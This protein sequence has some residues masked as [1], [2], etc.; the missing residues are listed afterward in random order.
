MSPKRTSVQGAGSCASHL[1]HAPPWKEDPE[2][3]G[4]QPKR[5]ASLVEEAHRGIQLIYRLS[6]STFESLEPDGVTIDMTANASSLST[7]LTSMGLSH[8]CSAMAA[9]ADREPQ[10]NQATF[11]SVFLR[12]AGA[13]LSSLTG[14]P[15]DRGASRY[16]DKSLDCHRNSKG[17]GWTNELGSSEDGSLDDAEALYPAASGICQS[18]RLSH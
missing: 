1:L 7:A 16:R 14:F 2:F 9:I 17:R 10:I 18:P 4:T 5:P 8:L 3:E 11:V 13:E 15:Q 12:W 6:E